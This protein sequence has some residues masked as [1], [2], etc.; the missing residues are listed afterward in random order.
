MKHETTPKDATHYD[1][2]RGLYFKQ[3]GEKVYCCASPAFKWIESIGGSIDNHPVIK[4]I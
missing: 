1:E 2:I 3:E 4:P